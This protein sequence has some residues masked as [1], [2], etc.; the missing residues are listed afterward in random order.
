MTT[1]SKK[2]RFKVKPRI[3][4]HFGIA[5]YNTTAK[6]LA[7]LCSNA[8]DADASVVKITYSETAISISDNGL[9]MTFDDL[10][11]GYLAL[12]RDRRQDNESQ[13]SP[14]GRPVIGNKGIGKLAGFGIAKTM[15]VDTCKDGQRTVVALN[16]QGLDEA[17]DLGTFTFP[18][19]ASSAP[20]GEHG[21]TVTLEEI[22][23]SVTLIDD[24]Q[25]RSYLARHLP[26]RPGWQIFVNNIECSP[27]DIPGE[28]FEIRDELPGLGTVTGYYV[29]ARDR[30]GLTPG[31]SV[32]VRGR[33][34]QEASLFDLN[35]QS[36]GYFNLVRIVGEL[37]PDFIDSVEPSQDGASGSF[38]INTSR[39]GFNPEDPSVVALEGYAR[40]KLEN[41]AHGLAKERSSERKDKALRRNPGFE[42]RLKQL[43]PEVYA[44]LDA[45]LEALIDKL[46]R[47]ET[48]ETVDEV[49]DMIIRYYES[50][51]LRLILDSVRDSAPEEVERLGELL[52]RY[53]TAQLAEVAAILSTQLEVISLLQ[54]K[55]ADGALE[56]EI[57][58]VIS[59]NIWLLR[60]DL[61]YW[62]DNRAFATQLEGR[63]ASEFQFASASRPDLVCFDDRNLGSEPGETPRR[64]VVIEFKRPGLVIGTRELAQV[65][66]YKNIFKS[67]LPGFTQDNIEVY[68]LGDSFDDAFDREGLSSQYVIL[69]YSELLANAHHR[70]Q[71]LFDSL[72]PPSRPTG[73]TET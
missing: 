39:S 31:F 17:V 6:A 70:Y 13:T 71:V 60:N 2:V 19:E 50:D 40:R 69:S 66:L 36:H 64:L 14:G 44:R 59:K 43:G 27:L 65:M 54:R 72:S 30:R 61:Q 58:E 38:V 8:Y 16:R 53:G 24:D 5:M 26:S 32:R 12:G 68:I 47:N 15:I 9:G 62:F 57:H 29:V 25:L 46:S 7:E 48:D 20:P 33:I 37:N 23:E 63:L 18:A 1:Q 73:P 4:D 56:K 21:T 45:S 22:L 10:T 3:L 52:A 67:S 34:V 11:E 42:E 51:S 49:V 35:Q 55:V 41:I 28:R